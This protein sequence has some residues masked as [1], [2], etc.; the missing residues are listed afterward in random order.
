MKKSLKRDEKEV[1]VNKGRKGLVKENTKHP[2]EKIVSLQ[3]LTDSNCIERKNKCKL[4]LSFQIVSLHS[5]F[6]Q[7]VKNHLER[8]N[9]YLKKLKA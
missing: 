5:K 9:Y 1:G 2:E 4:K 7:Q 6:L 8:S 3:K